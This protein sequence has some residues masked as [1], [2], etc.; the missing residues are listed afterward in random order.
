[1]ENVVKK[2]RER[3]SFTQEQLANLTGVSRQSIIS[4][5]KGHYI[6]TTV[7]ALKISVVLKV[8]IEELFILNDEDWK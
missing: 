3:L 8:R 7:L 6:P 5:E 4:I 1:M 2:Y